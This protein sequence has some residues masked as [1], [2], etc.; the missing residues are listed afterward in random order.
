VFLKGAVAAGVTVAAAASLD[1]P[2]SIV[3]ASS[4]SN[5]LTFDCS[6]STLRCSRRCRASTWS[7]PPSPPTA[8]STV[9]HSESVSPA[10]LS[11]VASTT[12]SMTSLLLATFVDDGALS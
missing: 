12:K 4:L 9:R 10:T 3:R 11:H 5:A 8:R 7:A 6:Y 2:L 1:V